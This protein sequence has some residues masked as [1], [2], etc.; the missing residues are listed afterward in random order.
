VETG[1]A[2]V[3][4][5]PQSIRY[6]SDLLQSGNSWPDYDGSNAARQPVHGVDRGARCE[7]GQYK[8]HFQVLHHEI[9]DFDAPNPVVLLT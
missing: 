8:W 3:W 4:V 5:I 1:G 7:V 6:R 9:W 2:N